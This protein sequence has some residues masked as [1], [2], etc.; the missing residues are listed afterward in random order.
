[1]TINVIFKQFKSDSYLIYRVKK[2]GTVVVII[3]V[4]DMLAIRDEPVMMD[5][6][7]CINK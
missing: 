2:L 7:E 3:Y 5:T 4:N 6:L 1:M